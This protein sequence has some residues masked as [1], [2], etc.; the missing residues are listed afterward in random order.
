MNDTLYAVFHNCKEGN[1]LDVKF[2][3]IFSS[4]KNI[5]IEINKKYNYYYKDIKDELKI[6]PIKIDGFVDKS[7][8]SHYGY[9]YD[10]WD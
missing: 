5:M 3:G 6:L 1:D 8:Y 7:L 10:D 2:L 4:K 9:N